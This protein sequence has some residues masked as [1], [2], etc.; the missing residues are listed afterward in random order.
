MA[1]LNIPD[2]TED[3]E[4]TRSTLAAVERQLGFT[5]LCTV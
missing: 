2:S 5:P 1:R 3:P 4:S